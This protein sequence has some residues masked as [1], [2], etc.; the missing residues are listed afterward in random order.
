MTITAA[1]QR[2]IVTLG[3]F[4]IFIALGLGRFLYALIVPHLHN[5]YRLSYTQI[6]AIGSFIILGYLFFSYIGGVAAHRIGEKKVIVTSLVVITLTFIT[7]YSAKN[8]VLLCLASFFMGSAAASIYM[9]IFPVVH[10]YFDENEYGK[11]MGLILSGAG[12]GVFALSALALLLSRPSELF[13]I[14]QVWIAC[15]ALACAMIAANAILLRPVHAAVRGNSSDQGFNRY[16]KIWK[17]VFSDA[18]LRNISVAYIFYGISY[19]GYLNY[20]VAYGRE[21]GGDTAS[22]FVWLIFGFASA[23]SSYLWGRWVD[24]RQTKHVLYCNYALASTAI[25]LSILLKSVI[26]I[27]ASSFLFGL[28]F[29]GYLTIV[30]RIVVRMT[31]ELS[32]VYMGKI[33]LLHAVGQVVGAFLGGLLR[34]LT[35]TFSFVFLLSLAAQVLSACF[36]YRYFVNKHRKATFR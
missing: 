29:F 26:S 8:I 9:S 20:I 25:L 22:I 35:S 1:K 5:V 17:I 23:F 19:A 27:F 4:N 6:G 31:G 34:D 10:E 21:L 7:F 3:F 33:T 28:C 15:A 24:R 16:T 14:F 18:E 36:F 30:G 13:N 32:S 12:C 2:Q 11:K